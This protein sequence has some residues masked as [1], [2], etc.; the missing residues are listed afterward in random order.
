MVDCLASESH[1]WDHL[2]PVWDALPPH[3]RGT[4]LTESESIG[5]GSLTLI[6]SERDRSSAVL[7][8]VVRMEHGIGMSYAGVDHGSWP[9]GR[10]Q[11]NVIAFLSPNRPCASRWMGAYPGAKVHI[12]G[13]P[14]MDAWKRL[15]KKEMPD[16]PLV[17]FSWHWD[18]QII[19]EAGWA[20][21][22]FKGAVRRLA[23]RS[24]IEVAVHCHP[25]ARGSI[26]P[27]ASLAGIRFIESFN[28]V[29]ATADVYAADTSSTL[30]EFAALDRPVIVMNSRKYRREVRHGIRFWD[31]STVGLNVWPADD[32]SA[33][34][35]LALEDRFEQRTGRWGAVRSLFPHLGTSTERAA[36]LIEEIACRS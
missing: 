32:L 9:G 7:R 30:Y 20:W 4:V 34:V 23:R 18:C 12:V 3:L 28:E 15:G 2:K 31:W 11:T 27:W 25:F 17:V 26:K 21:P 24:D 10:Y 36:Q 35:D 1:Y 33:A 14:R 5:F 13:V 6:A 19:P 8:P 29:L 16:R 22:E